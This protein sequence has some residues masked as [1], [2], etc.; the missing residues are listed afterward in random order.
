MFVLRIL[1]AS[2]SQPSF[3]RSIS[4]SDFSFSAANVVKMKDET[5]KIPTSMIDNNFFIVYPP[6]SSSVSMCCTIQ[7]YI[8]V[9]RTVIS[10]P[11]TVII[12]NTISIFGYKISLYFFVKYKQK[13]TTLCGAKSSNEPPITRCI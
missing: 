5:A 2:R 3:S 4:V 7:I 12:I 6:I 13:S 11:Y 9:F 10:V 8:K 1:N